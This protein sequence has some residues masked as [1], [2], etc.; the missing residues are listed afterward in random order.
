[1]SGR[2]NASRPAAVRLSIAPDIAERELS[3]PLNM[4]TLTRAPVLKPFTLALIQLGNI[5]ANKAENLKHAREMI[6]KA[7]TNH[8]SNK[9]PDLIVLPVCMTALPLNL[10]FL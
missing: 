5:G 9:K 8:G 2:L 7:A 6:Q 1:M 4:S 3:S 10:R